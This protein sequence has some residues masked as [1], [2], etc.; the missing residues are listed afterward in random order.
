MSTLK[1]LRLRISGV[2]STQKITKTMKMVAAS[3]L[4]KAQEQQKH[5]KTYADK[6]YHVIAQLSESV[7]DRDLTPLLVGNGNK[8]MYLLVTI[9][10][11]KGLCG[12][13]N[14][15]VARRLRSQIELLEEASK[16][17]KILCIGKKVFDQI[18]SQYGKSIIEVLPGMSEKQVKYDDAQFLS[19]KIIA[20]FGKNEFDVCYFIYNEFQNALKQNIAMRKLIPMNEELLSIE[21]Q[22]K[23]VYEYEPKEKDILQHLL[24]L[25]L[26]VQIYYILLEAG[27]SEQ[28]ARMTSMDAATNNAKDMI[29]K[30]TLLYNRSRQAAITKELIEIISSAESI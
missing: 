29:D 12:S 8:K 5:T 7:D 14:S 13:Y 26:A 20:W 19:D 30:L 28:G 22:E 9:G 24:P 11:D 1:Q 3:K 15:V 21:K 4:L 18:K 17:Y 6:M 2:K 16:N 27:A 10:S 25:N 23:H